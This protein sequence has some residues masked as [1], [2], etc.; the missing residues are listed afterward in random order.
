MQRS[1]RLSGRRGRRGT[2]GDPRKRFYGARKRSSGCEIGSIPVGPPAHFNDVAGSAPFY[3]ADRTRGRLL[4]G[5]FESAVT[6]GQCGKHKQIEHC[7]SH[8]AAEDYYRHG[9]LNLAP[10]LSAADRERQQAE[11]GHYGGH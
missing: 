4:L 2:E 5:P 6:H 1:R 11:R 3:G 9:T 8:Q 7:R 10:R